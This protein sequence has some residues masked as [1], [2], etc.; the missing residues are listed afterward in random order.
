[1]CGIM[2]TLSRGYLNSNKG[3]FMKYLH[4]PLESVLDEKRP[5]VDIP[6]PEVSLAWLALI[7]VAGSFATTAA[8]RAIVCGS[9]FLTPDCTY[10]RSSC[11]EET[12][13]DQWD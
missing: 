12:C 1:M 11:V 7:A 5:P 9:A 2:L 6:F 3:V 8:N 10:E 4:D 13:G